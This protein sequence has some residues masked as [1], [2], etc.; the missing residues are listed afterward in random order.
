MSENC[1]YGCRLWSCAVRL[2]TRQLTTTLD[3]S[4]PKLV[5]PTMLFIVSLRLAHM[6]MLF[7]SAKY[8]IYAAVS[9]IV[10]H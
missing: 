3:S 8:C 7:V 9:F 4:S 10:L 1:V 2:E 6:D 5:V